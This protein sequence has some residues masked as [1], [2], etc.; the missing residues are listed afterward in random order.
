MVAYVE[1]KQPRVV[2]NV[3]FTLR[4][5]EAIPNSLSRQGTGTVSGNCVLICTRR[6]VYEHHPLGSI[7]QAKLFWTK[8]VTGCPSVFPALSRRVAS[9]LGLAGLIIPANCSSSARSST[10]TSASSNSTSSQT[11]KYKHTVVST[12][13]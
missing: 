5:C 8:E 2:A 12:S 10:L 3:E 1:K 11:S 6:D 7:S 13:S 9:C 4:Q